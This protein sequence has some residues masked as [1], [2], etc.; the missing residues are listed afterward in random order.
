MLRRDIKANTAKVFLD[1]MN[2]I[3]PLES[4]SSVIFELVDILG[5]APAI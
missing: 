4:L 1:F 5:L 2:D 3:I